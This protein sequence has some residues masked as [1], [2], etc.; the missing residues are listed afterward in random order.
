MNGSFQSS[1]FFSHRSVNEL[2]NPISVGIVPFRLFWKR[3][4]KWNE[5]NNDEIKKMIKEQNQILWIFLSFFFF[6][7]HIF[8]NKFNNPISVGIVPFRLFW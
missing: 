3:K 7:S 5:K 2:S 4:L 8:P 6:F 1:S